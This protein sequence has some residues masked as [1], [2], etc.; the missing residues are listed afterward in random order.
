MT[1]EE[2]R[3]SNVS[4][5]TSFEKFGKDVFDELRTVENTEHGYREVIDSALVASGLDTAAS[6]ATPKEA[7]DALIRREIE[8][9]TDPKV[10][11]GY[12]LTK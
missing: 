2:A 1:L 5:E 3:E 10:N 4:A 7:L 6:F 12:Q 11:G 9:A 8:I